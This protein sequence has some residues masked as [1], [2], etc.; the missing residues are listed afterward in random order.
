MT[1][2]PKREVLTSYS[3][4]DSLNGH[5][6][7][8]KI[9]LLMDVPLDEQELITVNRFFD[10]F[11]LPLT[12]SERRLL[13]AMIHLLV[14][15]SGK[16]DT[17]P[18]RF[19][20]LGQIL[21]HLEINLPDI[22]CVQAIYHSHDEL[23]I[24]PQKSCKL[25]AVKAAAC[26][27]VLVS[28]YYDS[29][30]MAYILSIRSGC[31][32]LANFS[33][34]AWHQLLVFD[35]G[36]L[37]RTDR[38]LPLP[39]STVLEAQLMWE[40]YTYG[41]MA[42]STAVY[43][44]AINDFWQLT[45]HHITRIEQIDL[46]YIKGQVRL[47]R[48]KSEHRGFLKPVYNS[49]LGAFYHTL[50]A[51]HPKELHASIAD[52][53]P[54]DFDLV[55]YFNYLSAGYTTVHYSKYS[56][57]PSY[58]LWRVVPETTNRVVTVE[59]DGIKNPVLR[60]AAMHYIWTDLGQH[61]VVGSE[62]RRFLAL[63]QKMENAFPAIDWSYMTV[64]DMYSISS[65]VRSTLSSPSHMMKHMR[66]ICLCGLKS[67]VRGINYFINREQPAK[68]Q[69]NARAKRRMLYVRRQDDIKAVLTELQKKGATDPS[70]MLT[71]LFLALVMETTIR[72]S[73]A[74]KIK[75]TDMRVTASGEAYLS[76][77]HKTRKTPEEIAI[78]PKAQ[79][80]IKAAIV[81]GSDYRSHCHEAAKKHLLFLCPAVHGRYASLYADTVTKRLATLCKNMG[82]TPVLTAEDFRKDSIAATIEYADQNGLSDIEEAALT[83][84]A[85]R[86]VLRTSYDPAPNYASLLQIVHKCEIDRTVIKGTVVRKQQDLPFAEDGIGHCSDAE[87][88]LDSAY[89]PCVLCS[90]FV[91]DLGDISSLEAAIVSLDKMLGDPN[92]FDHEKDFCESRKKIY[93]S[94]LSELLELRGGNYAR[95]GY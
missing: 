15:V 64:E 20:T 44:N 95:N 2:S 33:I 70:S 19:S 45:P 89:S 6:T 91:V 25:L 80:I 12:A 94:Y 21:S 31:R 90:K 63:L 83:L 67:D 78:S 88:C 76:L 73:S 68:S 10:N 56:P 38:M 79:Q 30:K 40:A 36:I 1:E 72:M 28:D 13:E 5:D 62:Y 81:V 53:N 16:V 26:V 58:E 18:R 51:R 34:S 14:I 23:N 49:W 65:W 77:A 57:H 84:H 47:Q 52:L 29:E 17:T 9:K 7:E 54:D 3:I 4:L 35:R 59:F 71:Y 87:H 37:T 69:S 75:T 55:G 39:D 74:A 92:I 46:D 11:T 82:I 93:V 43:T 85:N 60:E 61:V 66:R 24:A 42:K 27:E 32:I 41:N 86:A 50:F 8:E 48:E 22:S